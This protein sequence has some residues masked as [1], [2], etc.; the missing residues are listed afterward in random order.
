MWVVA[1]VIYAV[2]IALRARDSV[3]TQ[4]HLDRSYALETI[5]SIRSLDPSIQGLPAQDIRASYAD[6]TDREIVKRIQER[7]MGKNPFQDIDF[8][9]IDDRYEKKSERLVREQIAVVGK[10]FIVWL[11]TVLVMYALGW[12]IGWIYRGFKQFHREGGA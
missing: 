11:V 7:W 5:D 6:L 1:A 8:K 4:E 10:A 12:S 2:F 3:P 9:D